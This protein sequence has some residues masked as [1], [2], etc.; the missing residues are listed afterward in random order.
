MSFKKI[1]K[2]Y[3]KSGHFLTFVTVSFKIHIPYIIVFYAATFSMISVSYGKNKKM[4][5][6]VIVTFLVLL[7][8][9]IY[10]LLPI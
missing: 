7:G 6:V 4:G 3:S 9:L 8:C 10:Y 1:K 5:Y 2:F